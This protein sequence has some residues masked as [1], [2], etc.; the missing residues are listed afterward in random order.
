MMNLHKNQYSIA[1]D[2]HEQSSDSAPLRRTVL[3]MNVISL[4][5]LEFNAISWLI[6]PTKGSLYTFIEHR[7]LDGN[8]SLIE[9][10]E[11]CIREFRLPSISVLMF[12]FFTLLEGLKSDWEHN[13]ISSSDTV[14]YFCVEIP[15]QVLP[16]HLEATN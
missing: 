5:V 15:S 9:G 16:I 2:K 7:L 13:K 11:K 6:G 12:F 8:S 4:Y 1:S 10:D 14:C 3:L